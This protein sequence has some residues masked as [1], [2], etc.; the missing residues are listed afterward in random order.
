MGA[1]SKEQIASSNKNAKRWCIKGQDGWHRIK[2]GKKPNIATIDFDTLC[3]DE[4]HIQSADRTMSVSYCTPTCARC[5]DGKF[6]GGKEMNP[7]YRAM[8]LEVA[9]LISYGFKND[10]PMV[11]VIKRLSAIRQI[12]EKEWTRSQ[13]F[14]TL[15]SNSIRDAVAQ[16][17]G[18]G[19]V[20]DFI[21]S[22]C[23]KFAM[24]KKRAKPFNKQTH[25]N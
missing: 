13:T 4:V 9:H 10:M 1:K 23:R 19:A 2:G 5:R 14:S 16:V 8:R 6:V 18:R 7:A 15:W 22:E 24:M 20:A 17:R 21:L 11:Q 3:G 12:H 25:E